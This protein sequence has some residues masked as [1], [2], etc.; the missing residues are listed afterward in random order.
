MATTT[1]NYGFTIPQSSDLV[2]NGATAIA[3]LGQ[4]IDDFI[5]G[6][7]ATGKLFFIAGTD[8][9]STTQTTTSATFVQKTDCQVTFT[10]GKSGVFAVI[11]WANIESSATTARAIVSYDVSGSTTVAAADGRAVVTANTDRG[12]ASVIYLHDGTPSTS[13]T[14]TMNMR[15]TTATTTTA[16]VYDAYI[17][18]VC[19]G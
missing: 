9:T 15:T 12:S 18:V 16:T 17:Q 7:S 19:L 4:N 11:L 10:T 13:T 14:V 1:T 5:A 6:S 3:T 8:T 2:R